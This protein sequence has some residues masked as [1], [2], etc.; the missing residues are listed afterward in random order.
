MPCGHL[1]DTLE[2][3]RHTMASLALQNGV[4]LA[5]VSEGLGHSD[6]GITARIYLHGS[7]ESDRGAAD[8]LDTALQG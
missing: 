3:M 7:K 6:T 5:T 2:T 4:D 1:V 8:A